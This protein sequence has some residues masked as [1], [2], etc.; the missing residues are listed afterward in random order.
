MKRIGFA[1]LL[2]LYG[3]LHSF[4]Q[5]AMFEKTFSM[6]DSLHFDNYNIY[7]ARTL[8]NGNTVL[9]G[10]G[11]SM[12]DTLYDIDT[13]NIHIKLFDED[14]NLL[15]DTLLL[16]DYFQIFDVTPTSDNGFAICGRM[17]SLATIVPVNP[18]GIPGVPI[19]VP[20]I[21]KN[22]VFLNMI[23]NDGTYYVYSQK[24]HFTYYQYYPAIPPWG[25]YNTERY[26]YNTAKFIQRVEADGQLSWRTFIDSS[27]ASYSVVDLDNIDNGPS[28]DTADYFSN[29]AVASQLSSYSNFLPYSF[30]FDFL[31]KIPG[32]GELSFVSINSLITVDNFDNREILGH[33]QKISTL[34]PNT[35]T[36]T[37]SQLV[38]Q[39][40]TD[41]NGVAWALYFTPLDSFLLGADGQY[42]NSTS[43]SIITKYERYTYAGQLIDSIRYIVPADPAYDPELIYYSS[44]PIVNDRSAH[45]CN[46]VYR[47]DYNDPESN[48]YTEKPRLIVLTY[49]NS[50][51]R[52]R[53]IRADVTQ[54]INQNYLLSQTSDGH[55]LTLVQ[56]SN[57]NPFPYL[58]FMFCKI[59]GDLND[60]HVTTFIDNN[61]NGV[62]DAGDSYSDKG[63]LE[64]SNGDSTKLYPLDPSGRTYMLLD[65]GEYNIRLISNYQRLS[66]YN[67]VPDSAHISFHG[68]NLQDSIVFR[69]VPKA[70]FGDLQVSIQPKNN[71]RPGFPSHYIL[72]LSNYG[73]NTAEHFRLTFVRDPRQAYD[74]ITD[75]TNNHAGD[76]FDT[77]FWV[78]CCVA[79][80]ET[81]TYDVGTINNPSPSLNMGDTLHLMVTI[82][83]DEGPEEAYPADNFFNLYE[84]VVNSYDPND[85]TEAHGA[86][87]NTQQLNDGEYLYYTIRFQN[88][89]NVYANN[90]V[91]RDTLSDKLDW[92]T[93]EM[94][95][96]SHYS[97]LFEVKN[98]NILSWTFPDINLPD[99]TTDE[100]NSHGYITFR[101]KPIDGLSV[102]DVINNR[103]SIFFD[104]NPA[105]ITN[106]VTTSIIEARIS[107]VKNNEI[108]SIKLYPSPTSDLITL[109]I[110]IK[111]SGNYHLQLFDLSGN[112]LL[113]ENFKLNSGKS[114]K[115]VSLQNLSAGMYLIGLSSDKNEVYS[116]KI[117][118]Q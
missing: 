61:N 93:L 62:Y 80:F 9:I 39:N 10:V 19:T 57:G 98:K 69:L 54:Y 35:G 44:P 29:W 43:D 79:P 37:G 115:Q 66:L 100:P 113:N 24:Y 23:E 111:Q 83:N 21:G 38:R 99:S 25:L 65:S 70:P 104:F 15:L 31:H 13:T 73:T 20:S 33:I 63:K 106:T 117:L 102:N 42:Y 11:S 76:M 59:R 45:I 78:Y 72:R 116:G 67:V 26:F 91:I 108:K 58:E 64:I 109:D 47:T 88:T 94:I 46:V 71:P 90:I 56:L 103:A 81:K 28:I 36:V 96:T 89:G 4:S 40:M 97:Y 87:L 14:A 114:L 55:Y 8:Y 92:N 118:K 77:L 30:L 18:Q 107:L 22:E 12:R 105:I 3:F 84:V 7:F 41:D 60:L 17:D 27:A 16:F 101:I 95:A 86:H 85:K 53:K 52:L 34:Q 110:D 49:D 112:M 32:S 5:S 68:L 6:A 50:L 75:F 2:L 1:I 82:T 48:V 51:R 74:S